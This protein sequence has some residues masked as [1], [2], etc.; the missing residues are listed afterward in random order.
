MVQLAF[1]SVVSFARTVFLKNDIFSPLIS[2]HFRISRGPNVR[3]GAD[4]T[5]T[6]ALTWLEWE[7]F[8][9]QSNKNQTLIRTIPNPIDEV[10][11]DRPSRS[12][13]ALE[14]HDVKYAGMR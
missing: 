11:V 10:W 1:Q 6:G 2:K 14:I 12:K 7:E 4:P 13:E 8:F 3:I 5:L 9:Q